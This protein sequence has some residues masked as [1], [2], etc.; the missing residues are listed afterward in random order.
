M[1]SVY[2]KT[3]LVSERKVKYQFPFGLKYMLFLS[4][5]QNCKSSNLAGLLYLCYVYVPLR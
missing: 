2:E 1:N 5:R 3:R 4:R